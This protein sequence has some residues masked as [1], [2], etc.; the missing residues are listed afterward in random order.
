MESRERLVIL[1]CAALLGEWSSNRRGFSVCAMSCRRSGVVDTMPGRRRPGRIEPR[2]RMWISIRPIGWRSYKPRGKCD[3]R[4]S[5]NGIGCLISQRRPKA[6]ASTRSRRAKTSGQTKQTPG[7]ENGPPSVEEF[8]NLLNEVADLGMAA[9][10]SPKSARLVE[11]AK[12]IGDEA[13]VELGALLLESKDASKRFCRRRHSRES[14]PIPPPSGYWDNRWRVKPTGLCAGMASH[15]IAL[16]GDS[17]GVPI[18]TK[19][20]SDPDIGVRVNAAF[21]L[22]AANAPG[23]LAAYQSFYDAPDTDG[24]IKTAL[25]G[26]FIML[27]SPE[28]VPFLDRVYFAADDLKTKLIVVTVLGKTPGEGAANLL[29]RIFATEP[30]DSVF[31]AAKAAYRE[32][33]GANE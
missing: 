27:K 13:I 19:L 4:R 7:K 21:G 29:E 26:G 8:A 25:L 24:F 2:C 31:D 30:E 32:T 6:D 14:L 9:Y 12:L 23:G 33:T 1:A 15:A 17:S 11:V 20:D 18:L 3:W 10:S 22:A 28:A 16:I 5:R